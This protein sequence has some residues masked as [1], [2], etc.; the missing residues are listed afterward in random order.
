VIFVVIVYLILGGS[1][2]HSVSF[3]GAG[4]FAKHIQ[5]YI[6]AFSHPTLAVAGA[7]KVCLFIN[8]MRLP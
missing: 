4:F 3:L 5:H 8:P 6:D 7:R 2:K 1:P